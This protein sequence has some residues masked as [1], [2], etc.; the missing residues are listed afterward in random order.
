[1]Y[2]SKQRYQGGS[3]AIFVIIGVILVA[4]LAGGGYFFKKHRPDEREWMMQVIVSTVGTSVI[5]NNLKS[6]EKEELKDLLNLPSEELA[7]HEKLYRKYYDALL[8]RSRVE[9]F[10][11]T[12]FSAE[13]NGLYRMNIS[14]RDR[15]VF[16]VSDTL[17]GKLCGDLL[18]RICQEKWKVQ[19][20]VIML[21][22]LQVSNAQKFL[23]EGVPSLVQTVTD[24]VQK[25]KS[26]RNRVILHATGGYKAVVPYLTLLGLMEGIPVKY[27]YEK[28]SELIEL[29][30]APLKFDER[31]LKD[32]MEQ[33][34]DKETEFKL[35][36][37][38]V[39]EL[40]E[41]TG[42]LQAQIRERYKNLLVWEDG[43][44]TLSTLARL[45]RERNMRKTRG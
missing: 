15:L 22:G 21:K 10:P 40:C 13:M 16:L 45:L 31:L 35:K 28:D 38:P 6:D 41:I 25:Y 23:R 8:E 4:G 5:Y 33:L 34:G 18:D 2:S 7:R 32:L 43:R 44:V 37:L 36:G 12:R 42:L 17:G 11:Y 9:P 24:I 14:E 39:N 29:P 19:T 30:A 27:V 3:T 20:E 1:M 26:P